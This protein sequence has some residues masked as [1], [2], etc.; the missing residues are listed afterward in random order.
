M[1][2]MLIGLE[3]E[4][5]RAPGTESGRTFVG[6]IRTFPLLALIGGVATLLTRTLGPWPLVIA[7]LGVTALISLTWFKDAESGHVGLTT[8]A[9]ALLTFL[10]GALALSTGV[11]EPLTR[12]VFVVSAVSV[13]ATVLL[14]S[15]A[16][17]REF[18][19]RLSRDDVI[20]TLKFLIVAV[21][22]LPVLPDESFGPWGVLNP[23]RIGVMVALIAGIGFVGY[24]AMRLWGEGR[25]LLLT[26]AI[27][28]LVSSTAVT[29]ASA[30]RAKQTQALAPLAALAV[31]VASSIMFVRVLVAV[32]VVERSLFVV[33]AWPLG[34]MALLSVVL[35]A[36]FAWRARRQTHGETKVDLANPFEL[37]SALKF[38]ALI[39]GIMLIS[40]WAGATF[41]SSGTYVTGV[42]A[43]LAD[44]DAITLSM[45]NLV[46]THEIEVPVAAR[47]IVLAVAS[48]TV[49]KGVLSLVL[50]G[51]AMGGR[52]LLAFVVVLTVGLAVVVLQ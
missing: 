26:A 27:G 45:A 3:R 50:G 8:E 9:S 40:R 2:G 6:G 38:A 51:R 16:Q 49:V 11:I 7:G 24:V 35:C 47:T 28:G 5:S 25:G 20:A 42:L 14:S 17:L 21:V 29:L 10:V 30:A 12:R 52:V 13:T 39:V 34:A 22:V 37:S 4:Q 18:S 36:I 1:A 48:N 43:G 19:T 23:F 15:K 44:V 31:V 46:K 41:G 32:F 33:L